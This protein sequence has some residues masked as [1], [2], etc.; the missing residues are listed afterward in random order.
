MN[1]AGHTWIAERAHENGVEIA[2]QHLEGI[3]RNGGSVAEV[4]VGAPIE[5]G[6]LDGRTAGAN[7]V[8]SVRNHFLADTVSGNDGDAFVWSREKR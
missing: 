2:G 1:V 3:G 5:A 8:E 6:E 7:D 4:A